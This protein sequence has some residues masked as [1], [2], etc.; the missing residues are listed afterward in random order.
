[1]FF[2]LHSTQLPS[3][4]LT[5]DHRSRRIKGLWVIEK[6]RFAPLDESGGGIY[7]RTLTRPGCQLSTFDVN[8]RIVAER[9]RFQNVR[10]QVSLESVAESCF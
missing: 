4:H 10:S 7:D 5:K 1:M 9:P 8:T 6:A 3:T 2:L